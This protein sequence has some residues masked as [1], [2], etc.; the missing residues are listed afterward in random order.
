MSDKIYC[1]RGKKSNYGIKLN[2]CIDDIPAEHIQE[3]KNGKRYVRLEVKERR[4]ADQW[5]NTHSIEVDTWKP[6]QQAAKPAPQATATAQE[7]ADLPF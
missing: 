6:N 4:E 7:I 1:G 2:V 5:G 3:A